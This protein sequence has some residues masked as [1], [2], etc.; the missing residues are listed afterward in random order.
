MFQ[1]VTWRS[2]IEEKRNKKA[3]KYNRFVWQSKEGVLLAPHQPCF[4]NLYFIHDLF[5]CLLYN[6]N[7]YIHNR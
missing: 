7:F 3:I 2:E 4:Q 5:I 1:Y 6:I